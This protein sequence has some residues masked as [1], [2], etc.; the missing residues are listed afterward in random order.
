MQDQLRGV[1]HIQASENVFAAILD[2]GSVVILDC[3]QGGDIRSVQV[4][5]VAGTLFIRK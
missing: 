5:E 2:S 1:K 4:Q 3:G